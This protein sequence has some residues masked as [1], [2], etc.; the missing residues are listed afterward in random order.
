LI[1]Y[2]HLYEPSKLTPSLT[3]EMMGIGVVLLF[4]CGL[5]RHTDARHNAATTAICGQYRQ[6]FRKQDVLGGTNRLL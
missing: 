2:L 5:A 3:Y 4:P 1:T 6:L